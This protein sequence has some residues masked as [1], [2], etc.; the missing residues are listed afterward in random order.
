VTVTIRS[1][2]YRCR[3]I[4]VEPTDHGLGHSRGGLATKI[5]LAVE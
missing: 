3:G 2:A 5:H 1:V 4:A